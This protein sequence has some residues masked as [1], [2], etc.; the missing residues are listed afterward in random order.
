MAPTTPKLSERNI[1]CALCIPVAMTAHNVSSIATIS[2]QPISQSFNFQPRMSGHA[3]HFPSMMKPM[4]QEVE[5]STKILET[6]GAGL[7]AIVMLHH[8]AERCVHHQ[9]IP[10]A[11]DPV[12]L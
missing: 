11:T 9:E 8:S 7:H 6:C 3:S 5:A 2:A 1:R 4:P 10:E 12:I